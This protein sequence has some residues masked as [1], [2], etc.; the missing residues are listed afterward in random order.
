MT[1]GVW[2]ISKDAFSVGDTDHFGMIERWYQL[3]RTSERK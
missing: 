3:E 2:E 1:M